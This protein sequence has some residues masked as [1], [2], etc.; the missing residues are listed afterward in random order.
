MSD[1]AHRVRALE[2]SLPAAPD[3]REF[4]RNVVYVVREWP[5]PISGVAMVGPIGD[6]VRL[7]EPH[8]ESDP[9]AIHLQ[10]LVGFGN[11]V[12]R[13]AYWRVEGDR[14]GCSLFTVLVGQTGKGRKGTSWGHAKGVLRAVDHDW[15]TDHHASGLAS[16]EG[17]IAALAP[18]GD[19]YDINDI[20]DKT[21]EDLDK[22]LMVVEPEF[23]RVLRVAGRDGNTLSSVI[24]QAWD[25]ATLRVMTRKQPLKADGAHISVVAHITEDELARELSDTDTLNGFANR[26][27]W[28]AVRRSKRLPFGGEFHREDIAPI[29]RALRVAAESA[30]HAGQ[31]QMTSPARALWERVYDGL[32]DDRGGLYGAAVGRSEPQVMRLALVYALSMR[33]SAIDEEHLAAALEVWRY[34]DESARYLFGGSTG[35]AVADR[36]L[37]F[38]VDQGEASR[39]Q[40]R[41]L[42]GRNADRDR[43]TAALEP[44]ERGGL[45]A[46]VE[47]KSGQAGRPTEWWRFTGGEASR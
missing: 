22:R 20:N 3:G 42:L 33:A 10:L 38:L 18:P 36:I 14:H 45:A 39:T 6:A 21:P 11:L 24:R 13:S 26:F 32:S 27:L 40:I 29:T 4:G 28:A 34:C 19:A 17:L 44:L 15:S 43:V 23:A 5:E 2:E 47:S 30:R 41:D 9:A 8:T 7:I 12:G 1:L 31:V 35:D 16:G 46:P 25:G 37:R